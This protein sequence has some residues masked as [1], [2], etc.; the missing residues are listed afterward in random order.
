M[1]FVQRDILFK[2]TEANIIDICRDNNKS[3]FSRKKML[4]VWAQS[5]QNRFEQQL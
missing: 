1:D 3:Q 4:K 5:P 2:L